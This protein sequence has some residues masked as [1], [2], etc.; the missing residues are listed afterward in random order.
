MFFLNKNLFSSVT[1]YSNHCVMPSKASE[2]K[3]FS[4][5]KIQVIMKVFNSKV[6]KGSS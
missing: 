5:L 6:K 1:E 2:L 4:D 3:F